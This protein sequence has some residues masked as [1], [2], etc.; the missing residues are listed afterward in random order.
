MYYSSYI[1]L[2][3]SLALVLLR[4]ARCVDTATVSITNEPAYS[5]E[6]AC[7][8]SCVFYNSFDV[9]DY[10]LFALGCTRFVGPVVLP[11]F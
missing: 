2:F 7:V 4:G 5:V 11:D 10:L 8:Q 1:A 9:A 6:P 3:S